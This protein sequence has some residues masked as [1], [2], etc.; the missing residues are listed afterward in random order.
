MQGWAGGNLK[1]LTSG[2]FS[3]QR[4]IET[5]E[6]RILTVLIITGSGCFS[7]SNVT[8]RLLF[9][10]D[11]RSDKSFCWDWPLSFP[12]HTIISWIALLQLGYFICKCIWMANSKMSLK[13]REY[14]NVTSPKNEMFLLTKCL[15]H[16][17]CFL[18]QT[19][20]KSLFMPWILKRVGAFVVSTR[21]K[22]SSCPRGLT[23]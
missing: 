9:N 11:N 8:V 12:C 15:I 17:A 2:D 5:Q 10:W 22:D 6:T 1:T 20:L 18:F 3:S 23:T 7:S 14:C 4:Q 21:V 19:K 13:S 16:F